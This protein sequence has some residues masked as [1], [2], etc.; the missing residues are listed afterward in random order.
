MFCSVY[1]MTAGK[2]SVDVIMANNLIENTR[3]TQAKDPKVNGPDF[4]R[5][6][7]TANQYVVDQFNSA[8]LQSSD[9]GSFKP[10]ELYQAHRLSVTKLRRASF[11]EHIQY[12][13]LAFL[14]YPGALTVPAPKAQ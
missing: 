14:R 5:E 8:I 12:L 9:H 13:V 2:Y 4:Q 6:P 10:L 3:F 7:H 1:S 11:R